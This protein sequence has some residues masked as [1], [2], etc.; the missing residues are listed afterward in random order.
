MNVRWSGQ[1]KYRVLRDEYPVDS[2]S[3]RTALRLLETSVSQGD[4]L[5]GSGAASH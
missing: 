5:H 4:W 2:T 1:M 3:V